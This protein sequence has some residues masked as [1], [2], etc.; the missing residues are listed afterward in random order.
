LVKKNYKPYWGKLT[1]QQLAQV[2]NYIKDNVITD[3]KQIIQFIKEQF[4]IEYSKSGIIY[5]INSLGFSY[6][7]LTLFPAKSDVEKQ[8]EFV[9]TYQQLKQN[10]DKHDQ[11]LFI[12]G[13]HPQHNTRPSKAWIQKG[14]T[15]YIKTNTGR[16]RIN[17][18]GAYNPENQ[19]I[20]IRED[21][22]INAQSTIEL[23]KQIEIHYPKSRKIYVI[24]D[25]ARYYRC[26]L[27]S[28]YLKNSKIVLI[29]LP[30][31][32][33]N[34]NLIERL[35]KYMRKKVINTIYYQNFEDF[36]KA[37]MDFFQNTDLHKLEIA[38]F[39]GANFHLIQS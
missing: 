7:Q 18:N 38:Q 10:L 34:L 14:V 25:N 24:A 35:W 36:K 29:F 15:K 9:N 37:I 2:K 16:K 23:F 20:I 39:V 17:L 33:P 32:S 5:L 4:D 1:S 31:Y 21:D 26:R 12:D 27:V 3:S 8:K 13:V 30:P 11:M 19:D 28:E 22:S 6:K